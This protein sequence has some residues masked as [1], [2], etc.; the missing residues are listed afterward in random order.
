MLFLDN[1]RGVF[2]GVLA[3]VCVCVCVRARAC[4]HIVQKCVPEDMCMQ[5]VII[6]VTI[7]KTYC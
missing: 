3:C 2:W 5:Q 1:Y 4:T 6:K 7:F